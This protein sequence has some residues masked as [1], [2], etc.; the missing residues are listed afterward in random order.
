MDTMDFDADGLLATAG[1][2]GECSV[3]VVGGAV[4]VEEEVPD[5]EGRVVGV[6]KVFLTFEN[7]EDIIARGV[8]SL[9]SS[10]KGFPN[11]VSECTS[12]F[13]PRLAPGRLIP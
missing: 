11:V 9:S 4:V 5:E 6:A 10:P 7:R 12:S 1:I 2:A 3:L 13:S 8:S